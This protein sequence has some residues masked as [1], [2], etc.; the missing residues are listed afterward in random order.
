VHWTV[1]EV[2]SGRYEVRAVSMCNPN[3]LLVTY[4]LGKAVSA[5]EEDCS[6][7]GDA[8]GRGGS[9][10]GLPAVS[11]CICSSTP[12]SS[13]DARLVYPSWM[14][15]SLRTTLLSAVVRSAPSSSTWLIGAS[16]PPRSW[17]S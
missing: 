5:T 15:C 3:S 13:A 1:R 8:C 17:R 9:Y 4:V 12:S 16:I 10:A 2:A 11:G 6:T 14:Y 7:W